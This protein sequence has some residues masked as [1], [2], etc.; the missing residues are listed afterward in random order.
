M[1]A[2]QHQHVQP[3]QAN[4]IQM[5]TDVQ[6]VHRKDVQ[7]VIQRVELVQHVAV[8]ITRMEQHV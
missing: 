7:R 3:A 1:P 8:G 6:H 5:E 4:I 2:H